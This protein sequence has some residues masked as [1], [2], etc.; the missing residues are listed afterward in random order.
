MK[1]ANTKLIAA[2]AAV[3]LLVAAAGLL[4]G[5]GLKPPS[6]G[7]GP[8]TITATE[9]LILPGTESPAYELPGDTAWLS[10]Q[11][12]GFTYAPVPLVTE[13]DY[14][15]TR[16]DGGRNT[17]HVTRSS[18]RMHSADCSTQDCVTQGAVTLESLEWRPLGG[19]IICLPHQLIVELLPADGRDS[20]ITLGVAAE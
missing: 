7:K 1:N 19:Q 20:V 11:A 9:G 5:G 4:L 6:S 13:G 2:L 15:F 8:L 14:T 16:P 3:T 12:E 18:M 17:L 10:V